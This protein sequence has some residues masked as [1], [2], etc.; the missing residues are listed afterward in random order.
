MNG[1]SLPLQEQIETEAKNSEDGC[2]YLQMIIPRENS[3]NNFDNNDN[4]SDYNNGFFE[5]RCKIIAYN[6]YYDKF[7]ANH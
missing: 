3:K 5:I 1:T 7:V 4:Y 2:V 6:N